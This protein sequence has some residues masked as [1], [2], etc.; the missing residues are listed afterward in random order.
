MKFSSHYVAQELGG[1]QGPLQELMDEQESI[2]A[3]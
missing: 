1:K 3:L 2:A